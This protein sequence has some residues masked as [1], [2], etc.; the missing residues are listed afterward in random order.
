MWQR[1]ITTITI[2]SN[3]MLVQL[4]FSSLIK[5]FKIQRN[6]YSSTFWYFIQLYISVFHNSTAQIFHIVHLPIHTFF[7]F[8]FDNPENLYLTLKKNICIN[9][10]LVLIK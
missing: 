7:F 8:R 1:E 3:H 6:Y 4:L 2:P 10:T 5:I 9:K